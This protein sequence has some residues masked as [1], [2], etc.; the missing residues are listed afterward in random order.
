[1]EDEKRDSFIPAIVES[2]VVEISGFD[3]ILVQIRPEWQAKSLIERVKRLLPVDPSSACQRLLNATIQDL[4]EKI[5][6]AGK[7][8]AKEAAGRNKLPPVETNEDILENYSTANIID[9]TYRMGIITRPEWRRIQRCYDIRKDLEHEDIDYEAQIEDLIYIFKPCIEIVLSKDPVQLIRIP[10][11]EEF[12]N[13]PEHSIPTS[14]LLE[15]YEKAPE[16]R[17]REIMEVLINT[18]LNPKKPDIS[19]QNAMELIRNFRAFTKD[20]VKVELGQLMQ[21]RFRKKPLEISEAKTF[22]GAGILPYLKQRQLKQFF[23]SYAKRFDNIHH[24][25]TNWRDHDKLLDDFEDVGGLVICPPDTRRKIVLWMTL[26]FIGEPGGYGTL[27]HSRQVFYSDTAAPRI[28]RMFKVA[29]NRISEDFEHATKDSRVKIAVQNKFI[30]R[31]LETIKD[32]V[33]DKF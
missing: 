9:L 33:L 4:R 15:E 5:V 22:F 26:C 25:W 31:R 2:K 8:I 10:D 27:G 23:E 28:E 12:I 32:S 20:S 3:R 14:S 29:G 19:R 17:Q 1:M 13:A 30:A 6:I 11:V 21:D 16:P 24:S 18:A 7:D